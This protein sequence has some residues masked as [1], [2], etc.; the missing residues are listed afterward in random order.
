MT[1]HVH[2]ACDDA[3]YRAVI[4]EF[5]EHQTGMK[6]VSASASGTIGEACAEVAE[7]DVIVIG[8]PPTANVARQAPR[9][10]RLMRHAALVAFCMTPEQVN[11]Y[12]ELGIE[13]TIGRDEPAR[14]LSAA[15]RAAYSAAGIH[16]SH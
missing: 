11:I 4:A 15:V 10:R 6:V 1:I 7:P 9:Y 16:R 13:R 5:L 3:A 14:R 8:M 12:H 2:V